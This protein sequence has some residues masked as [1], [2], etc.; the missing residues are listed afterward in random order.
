M[1][2][3]W[4]ISAPKYSS[5]EIYPK[6][7]FAFWEGHRDFAYD[8]INF[9]KP[10]SLLELGSQYGCS[11]FA[12]CQSIK[13]N[14]LKTKVCAVDKWSGDVGAE[15]SGEEVFEIVGKIKSAYFNHLDIALYPMLFDDALHLFD[16]NSFDVIHIDGSHAYQDVEHDFTMWLPKL[17][18]DGI[19]LF[20]DVFSPI[21]SGACDYWEK[22][23][24]DY[25]TYFEFKHSCGLGVLFPKGDYWYKQLEDY[26]FFDYIYDVYQYRAQYQ[27]TNIRFKELE[28]RFEERFDA[29]QKQSKMIDD[30]DKTIKSQTKMIDERDKAIASQTKM[31]DERDKAIESQTKM[32]D[33]RDKAIASQAKMIDERDKIINE[34]SK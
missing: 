18:E 31:I 21:E 9:V 27:I 1:N 28:K 19:I 10:D 13:D 3:K 15:H 34:L 7:R 8:F 20:H 5:D 11:L 17:K 30:R 25:E 22:I 12:F 23:K 33:E 4:N 24:S 29:I 26:H 2:F 6:L 14:N 32:I 16:D